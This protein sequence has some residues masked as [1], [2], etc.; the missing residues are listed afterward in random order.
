[1]PQDWDL[2]LGGNGWLTIYI[3]IYILSWD[4]FKSPEAFETSLLQELA[5]LELDLVQ[6]LF[7]APPTIFL[8]CYCWKLAIVRSHGL[9][10]MLPTDLTTASFAV[11]PITLQLFSLKF[12]RLKSWPTIRSSQRDPVATCAS[13]G[14]CAWR[15]WRGSSGWRLVDVPCDRFLTF[16]EVTE[17]L[18]K[19]YIESPGNYL[20]QMLWME[21]CVVMNL[22]KLGFIGVVSWVM[23][24]K[25]LLDVR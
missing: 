8:R 16:G 24:G 6:N 17:G 1:M 9:F 25:L 13:Y 20:S 2:Y 11:A 19:R 5:S 15:A 7:E 18:K 12:L 23:N 21:S 10:G 3:Y 14:S 4:S 22:S